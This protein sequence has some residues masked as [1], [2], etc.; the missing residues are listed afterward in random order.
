[1]TQAMRKR[2]AARSS[3]LRSEFDGKHLTDRIVRWG[4]WGGNEDRWFR[5]WS[6]HWLRYGGASAF[7]ENPLKPADFRAPTS[8]DIAKVILPIVATYW[9]GKTPEDKGRAFG[10]SVKFLK[11]KYI[12]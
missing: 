2:L 12:A 3:K 9:G 11:I 8:F 7:G 10:K 1:M 6:G 5:P 4:G